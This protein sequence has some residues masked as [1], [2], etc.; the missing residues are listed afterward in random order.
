MLLYAALRGVSPVQALKD[1]TS[2][3][4]PAV[5][6]EGKKVTAEGGGLDPDFVPGGFGSTPWKGVYRKAKVPKQFHKPTVFVAAAQT[7]GGEKYSQGARWGKGTSDCASFVGKALLDIGVEP[8][9][10]S[11]TGDYLRSGQWVKVSS[12]RLGDICVNA[13]H[14]I[15]CT[16]GSSGIGMQNPR[17]NVSRDTID[18]LMANSG[19]YEVR[20]YRGWS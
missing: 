8:P 14:M 16:S 15:V 1:V 10:G 2:G 11:T 5:S 18:N 9:G 3:A 17:R 19:G 6:T 13:R 7:H 12:P 20:R 4:P